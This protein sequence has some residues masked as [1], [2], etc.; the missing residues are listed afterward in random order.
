MTRSRSRRRRGGG[1]DGGAAPAAPPEGTLAWLAGRR[2]ASGAPLI[3]RSELEAGERLAAE[4]ERAERVGRVTMD[5]D[6]LDRRIDRPREA[7]DGRLSAAEGIAAARRRVEAALGELEPDFRDLLV[8]VCCR[9][10]GLAEAERRFGWPARAGKVVLR[11]ALRA[12]AR[13]Y[14][15]EGVGPSRGSGVRA[16]GT[17]DHRPRA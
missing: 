15:L 16:W 12:L 11:Y 2:D 14:R 5:W 1:D 3:E 6:G 7:S 4:W 9:N 17:G 13:H 8:A 10:T